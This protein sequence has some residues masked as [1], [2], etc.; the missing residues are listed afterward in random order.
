[1]M[2]TEDPAAQEPSLDTIRDAH[3]RIRPHIHR[4]PV[5]SSTILNRIAGAEIFF[6]CENF[7]KVAAFKARGACNAVFSLDDGQTRRGVV[8]HSSG[9]HGAALAWAAAK[10][11][12]R[13]HIVMPE[14]SAKPKRFAV[15]AYGGNV[16]LCE[17][18]LA[19]REATAARLVDELGAVLVHPYND[20]RVIAGQGTAALELLEDVPDLEIVMAPLGGGGLLSGTA[21]AVK[22]LKPGIR[23]LGAEPA[24]AD[25]GFRSFRSGALVTSA[26][27]N[28][29]CD[30]LRSMVGE[31]NFVIIRRDVDDIVLADEDN[32]VKAMRMIWEVMKFVVEPSSSTPLAA[33][34]QGADGVKGRK[35]GI[36][37]SG[38][39]VDLDSLPWQS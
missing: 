14:N 22:G 7:Q 34:L 32:V 38:G 30:G 13:A 17:P 15:E 28:T 19:A 8:T 11:G 24:A 26:V 36:I 2:R 12:A 10:R 25:D 6:K 16:V 33:L 23:V 5:A 37:L 1:M 3:A 18:T 9:N 35:V 21:I 39:N 29:I 20:Y 27:N 4:T 31:K